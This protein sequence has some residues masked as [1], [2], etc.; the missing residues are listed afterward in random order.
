M[1]ASPESIL[2]SHHDPT[3]Y[4]NMTPISPINRLPYDCL[5]EIFTHACA[6]RPYAAEN[7]LN[8]PKHM[9][10]LQLARVCS[11][12]RKVLL[13]NTGLWSKLEF[14]HEPPYTQA[15]IDCLH[16]YLTNSGNHSLTFIIQ[17]SDFQDPE[18][19]VPDSRQ[20]EFMRVLCIEAHRWKRATFSTKSPF[21]PAPPG[22]V[23]PSLLRLERL[24]LCYREKVRRQRRDFFMNA[25]ALR[26]VGVQLHKA[27]KNNF[28]LPWEQ[29]SDLTLLYHSSI[30][31]AI[32]ILPSCSK[33]QK[34]KFSDPLMDFTGPSPSPTVLNGVQSLVIVAMASSDI[35]PL[36]CFPDLVSLTINGLGRTVSPGRELLSL[37]SLPRA[38]QLQCLIFDDTYI[39]DDLVLDILALTPLLHTLEKHTYYFDELQ[40][41]PV[42][43][44]FGFFRRLTLTNNFRTNLAPRLKTLK[45]RVTSGLPE[46]LIDMLQS[47]LLGISNLAGAVH[48]DTVVIEGGPRLVSL[49]VR[50]QVSQMAGN[51]YDFCRLDN[52][53][54]KS[55]VGFSLS[56]R[57]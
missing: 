54:R 42:T 39:P 49:G 7:Y 6:S 45:I 23:A 44:D 41:V 22:A 9:I 56:K 1:S 28:S 14:I 55:S 27:K 30:S 11:H 12:W 47:R 21:F 18:Y 16:L 2:C 25:P 53:G 31:R 17:D 19:I 32:H 26:S 51:Q 4:N 3:L 35:I 43:P 29:I 24:T 33:L 8:W 57:V 48:L 52:L 50:D 5:S 20:S 38:P 13:S 46:D 15:T 37:L 34:L 36:F 40:E 10:A